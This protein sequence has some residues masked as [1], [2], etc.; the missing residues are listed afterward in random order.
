MT[1]IKSSYGGFYPLP[2]E[3]LSDKPNPQGFS[4]IKVLDLLLGSPCKGMDDKPHSVFQGEGLKGALA[5][6]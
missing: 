4:V 6:A 3:V 5:Y 2:V 1:K